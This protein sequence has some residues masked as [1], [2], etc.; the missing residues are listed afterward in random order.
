MGNE[1]PEVLFVCVHNAGRSQMAAALL[2]HYAEGRVHVRSAGSTPADQINPAV[3]AVMDEAGID[4]SKEFPKPL[5]IEAVE[6]ADVV[7][8]MGCGDACP[9]FPGKRYLD[10]ELP[11][12]SGMPVEDVRPIRDRIDELVRELLDS[13]IGT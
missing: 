10:W 4:L 13:L 5:S 7:V 2:E 11:D 8:T 1:V 12:P 3:I 6:D 9:V